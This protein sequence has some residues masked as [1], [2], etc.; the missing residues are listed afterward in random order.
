MYEATSGICVDIENG[1]MKLLFG[2]RIVFVLFAF[3][4]F[5]QVEAQNS[6]VC[7]GRNPRRGGRQQGTLT[8]GMNHIKLPHG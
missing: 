2:H 3:L 8:R 1:P 6:L 7:K 4:K 5:V